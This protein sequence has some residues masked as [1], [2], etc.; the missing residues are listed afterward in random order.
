MRKVEKDLE[1]LER[2]LEEHFGGEFAKA[3]CEE[4]RKRI[5]YN[6][7]RERMKKALIE[8]FKESFKDTPVPY[9]KFHARYDGRDIVLVVTQEGATYSETGD[10]K[11]PYAVEMLCPI[12]HPR[13]V[14]IL[15]YIKTKDEA[16][17]LCWAPWKPFILLGRLTCQKHG[18]TWIPEKWAIE[19]EDIIELD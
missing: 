19:V 16:R 12:P 9:S 15:A 2:K 3:Y 10:F 18:G 11:Y 7:M 4:L 6:E 13:D 5:D 8:S 14:K 1:W 17:K